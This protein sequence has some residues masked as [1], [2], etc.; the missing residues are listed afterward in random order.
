[1]KNFTKIFLISSLISISFMA[2]AMDN[3]WESEEDK[4]LAGTLGIE[5]PSDFYEFRREQEK[6]IESVKINVYSFSSE[7]VRKQQETLNSFRTSSTPERKV[8][9]EDDAQNDKKTASLFYMSLPQYPKWKKEEEEEIASLKLI[10]DFKLRE[11]ADRQKHRLRA[12]EE[13]KRL[14]RQIEEERNAKLAQRFQQEEEDAHLARQLQAQVVISP[15][16]FIPYEASLKD[17]IASQT[18]E[19][20][21]GENRPTLQKFMDISNYL[22]GIPQNSDVH[23]LDNYVFGPQKK[24]NDLLEAGRLY[25]VDNGELTLA[26]VGQQ[27]V[28]FANDNKDFFATFKYEDTS[29][30]SDKIINILNSHFPKMDNEIK[31]VE[32]NKTTYVPV[33]EARELWSRAWTLALNLYNEADET[34]IQMI[35]EQAVEGHLTRGGCIQGRIDRGFVGYVSLLAKAGVNLH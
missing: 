5:H 4:T 17:Q 25:N 11:E 21:K 28:Q 12:E 31:S 26:E 8:Q 6:R 2:N 18:W 32:L 23:V 1:M 34:A 27:M 35:F 10:N 30:N 7:E 22:K 13:T 14:I 15:A 20:A 9:R 33:L 3:S 16:P 29:L 24:I 19:Y